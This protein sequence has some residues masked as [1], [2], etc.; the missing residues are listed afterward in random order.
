[1]VEKL[2]L[3][4]PDISFKFINNN[5]TKLHT[6]GN[7]NRKDIIYHIFGREISSS[8]LEVKH[9]CEYF[10]VEGFIGKPVITRGNRNY[11]NYFINGRYVKSNI[12]SRAIEEAY[13]SFLMQHQYPF[14]VLY[15]TFSVSWM[16][17]YIRPRWS[18]GST[19]TTRY[20]LN[21]VTQY[22]QFYLIRR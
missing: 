19:T 15:F 6:S 14:T 11:E 1:M 10:K 5:Q 9:E 12:L 20:M 22:M 13:K 4:H 2:A 8:L 17:T 7:G 21:C 3:S 16:S 18:L